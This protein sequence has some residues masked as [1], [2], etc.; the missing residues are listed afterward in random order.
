MERSE[1]SR[2]NFVGEVAHYPAHCIGFLDETSKNDK[3]PARRRGRSRKGK[4]AV[5]RQKF[6]RGP[7]L[8]ATGL[9]TCQGML[10]STVVEGSMHR[11]QYLEF[12]EHQVVSSS[13]RKSFLHT[14][15][16]RPYLASA[17]L[18]FSWA[19]QRTH[20]GQCPHPPW[21]GNSGTL[22]PFPG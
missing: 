19:S 9:L 21:G 7:R 22:R 3:T 15:Y 20:Y 11:D 4:R 18:P 2:N 17:M 1:P 13:A 14:D 10:A 5:K 8:T 16:M 6:V 12:L